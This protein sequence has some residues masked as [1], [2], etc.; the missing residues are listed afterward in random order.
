MD[1]LDPPTQPQTVGQLGRYEITGVI[2]QGGM[3]VVLKARDPALN[4]FVAIKVLSPQLASSATAGKRFTREAQMAAAV[5]HDHVVTIHAVDAAKGLPFLVME[6]IAG[7]SLEE[8]IRRTGPLKVEEILRIGMQAASGL[9]AAHAQG[10]VHRDIKPSNILL[11]NGVERV[12][13]TDFGLARVVHEAKITKTGVVAGTPEYMSPEQA[14]GEDI[15]R[16]SDL[17]S[18]GC[19]MYAMCTGHSPFRATTV[20]GAIHRVCEDTPRPIRE[21]NPD[22]PDWLT[23]IID[24]LLAKKP[25]ERF[26]TAAEVAEVLGSYLAHVQ[27]TSGGQLPIRFVPDISP[28]ASRWRS[29]AWK[30]IAAAA[31]FCVVLFGLREF[32]NDTPATKPLAG[33]TPVE[34]SDP[35]GP[36]QPVPDRYRPIDMDE[37]ATAARTDQADPS[38]INLS[39]LKTGLQN[40]HGIPFR[41]GDQYILLGGEQIAQL[42]GK[43]E[44]IRI[45]DVASTLHFLHGTQH[46]GSAE[47]VLGYYSVHYEDGFRDMIP[48]VLDRD[49][50]D[51]RDRPTMAN[52]AWTGSDSAGGSLSLCHSSWTNPRPEKRIARIGFVRMPQ[53]NASLFCVALTCEMIPQV[54][55]SQS[56]L[57]LDVAKTSLAP[58]LELTLSGNDER[59]T[60]AASSREVL[61]LKPGDYAVNL[62]LRSRQRVLRTGTLHLKAGTSQRIECDWFDTTLYPPERNCLAEL[63]GHGAPLTGIVFSHDGKMLVVACEDGKAYVWKATSSQ[64]LCVAIL[65]GHIGSVQCVALSEDDK[66]L[67]TGGADKRVLLWDLGS[68]AVQA[69]LQG[70]SSTVRSVTFSPDGASIA[71]IDFTGTVIVWDVSGHTEKQRF[72]A[73]SGTSE[74][75]GVGPRVTYSPDGNVLA[76]AGKGESVKLW[77]ARTLKPV[78]ELHGVSR[79]VS[80]LVFSPDG[81]FVV[82]ADATGTKVWATASGELKGTLP[83][84]EHFSLSVAVSADGRMAA[85]GLPKG[86]RLFDFATQTMID[87]FPTHWGAM[88]SMAFCSN[89]PILATAGDDYVVRL[90]DVSQTPSTPPPPRAPC[91]CAFRSVDRPFAVCGD[92]LAVFNYRPYTI[93][94]LD[95]ENWSQAAQISSQDLRH[96]SW[97]PAAVC[98]LSDSHRFATTER[99]GTLRLWDFDDGKQRIY[100]RATQPIDNTSSYIRIAASSD[101]QWLAVPERNRVSL[102]DGEKLARQRTLDIGEGEALVVAFCPRR[103]LLAVGTDSGQ[104]MLWDVESGQDLASFSHGSSRILGLVFSPDGKTLASTSEESTVRLWNVGNVELV[105]ETRVLEEHTG[106]VFSADFSQDGNWLVTAGGKY[107]FTDDSAFY[108]APTPGEVK[109]WNVATGH[110]IADVVTSD[111]CAFDARFCRDGRWLVVEGG[112]KTSVW[113]VEQ[114]LE[115]A[116]K[117]ETQASVSSTREERD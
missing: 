16:R 66:I 105:T 106:A 79:W 104:L 99:S 87:A 72:T 42:P 54:P 21:V 15:D 80:D 19:V 33:P 25:D 20:T 14:R 49:V 55:H 45:G 89:A 63:V 2:G 68:G 5:S 103:P 9:A 112:F 65:A 48:I 62:S 1:F 39:A 40:L 115:Y 11:E 43:V 91:L 101:G 67:A 29:Y 17:F 110:R 51:C 77:D 98:F 60:R 24:R 100:Q 32:K 18:L 22:I 108:Q 76:T 4:R 12:K 75:K 23:G 116:S 57:V 10:L 84:N 37:Y 58:G 86:V 61:R 6:Y 56:T 114:V 73:Q 7:V 35:E 30:A 8:R 53:M 31:C 107:D 64:W 109:I 113:D 78:N 69:S 50:Q 88:A 93:Q 26:Q 83:G 3:G 38:T 81:T 74:W 41:I 85:C 94:L 97:S 36:I 44:G 27:Q 92:I 52:V 34:V 111:M 59:I 70:H 95:L 102:F 96:G 46:S 71:S 90:W 82:A 13:I 28:R 117:S 47:G